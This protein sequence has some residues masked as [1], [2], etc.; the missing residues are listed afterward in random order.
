MRCEVRETERDRGHVFGAA[1]HPARRF[2]EPPAGQASRA[3]VPASGFPHHFSY[4]AVRIPIHLL[5]F[6]QT[7]GPVWRF[8][9]DVWGEPHVP[10]PFTFDVKTLAR[11]D[12]FRDRAYQFTYELMRCAET[13]ERVSVASTKM[14]MVNYFATSLHLM[15][16]A[17]MYANYPHCFPADL[18]LAQR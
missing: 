7:S 2:A 15:G 17:A 12:H 13:G 9:M 14:K 5:Q 11:K 8:L 6:G 10:D 1:A 18:S 3:P 4:D 16:L